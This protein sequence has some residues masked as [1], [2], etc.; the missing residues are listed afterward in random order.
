MITPNDIGRGMARAEA[1][2]PFNVDLS[3]LEDK[4]SLETEDEPLCAA[5]GKRIEGED[6]YGQP[7][8]PLRLFRKEDGKGLAIHLECFNA[9]I[10]E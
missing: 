4:W 5:C 2:K 1:Y 10:R 9:R 8:I 7:N 6:E 3:D